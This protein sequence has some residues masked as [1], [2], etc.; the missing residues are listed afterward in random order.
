MLLEGLRQAG[1]EKVRRH[2]LPW[3]VPVLLPRENKASPHSPSPLPPP[4]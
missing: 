4:G 3:D 2:C 1:S